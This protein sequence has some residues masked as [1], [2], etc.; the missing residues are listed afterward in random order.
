MN[1]FEKKNQNFK[2]YFEVPYVSPNSS[3]KF[4]TLGRKVYLFLHPGDGIP[5]SLQIMTACY[6]P[7]VTEKGVCININ[8][9]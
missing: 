4:K 7:D 2:S 6:G 9:L 8:N 5:G 3:M 1:V